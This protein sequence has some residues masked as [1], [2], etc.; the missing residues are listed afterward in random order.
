[1]RLR[2]APYFEGLIQPGRVNGSSDRIG[3]NING[4]EYRTDP[5]L[6]LISI[7]SF[8]IDKIKGLKERNVI[9]KWVDKPPGR[10][11]PEG[12]DGKQGVILA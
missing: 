12:W 10:R 7:I 1:M 9:G 11:P 6:V 8:K 2:M 4:A 3:S 5:Y